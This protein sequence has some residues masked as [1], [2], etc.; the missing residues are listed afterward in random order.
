[1]TYHNVEISEQGIAEFCRKWRITEFA[2]FGSVLRPDIRPDS[3]IDVLIT[4]GRDAPWSLWDMND[5]SDELRQLLGREVD[6][7]SK[8]ALE[9]PFRRHEILTT[10]R[11]IYAA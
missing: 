4:F 11:V 2:L 7:V 8:R 10:R 6:V 9:N 3:D 5:L 1:M